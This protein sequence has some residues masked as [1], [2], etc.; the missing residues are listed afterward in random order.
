MSPG[1]DND[2]ERC[3]RRP[4]TS[5]GSGISGRGDADDS[6]PPTSPSFMVPIRREPSP[7]LP[8]SSASS[9]VEVVVGPDEMTLVRMYESS[10]CR[11]NVG[12]RATNKVG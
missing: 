3:S 8:P 5:S 11:R 1:D 12:T 7:P 4:P 2:E 6:L 9:I 10:P